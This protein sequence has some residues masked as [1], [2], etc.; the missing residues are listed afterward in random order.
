MAV[1]APNGPYEIQKTP[2]SAS[3][4]RL[5]GPPGPEAVPRWPGRRA[6]GGGAP[7]GGTTTGPLGTFSLSPL[8]PVGRGPPSG[9]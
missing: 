9:P 3:L 8:D 7:V 1:I 5:P 6:G 2:P 4:I